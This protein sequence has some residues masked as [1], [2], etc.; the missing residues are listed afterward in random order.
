MVSDQEPGEKVDLTTLQHAKVVHF[1]MNGEKYFSICSM[2]RNTGSG[3]IDPAKTMNLTTD[4]F[5]ELTKVLP[6][7]EEALKYDEEAA[8]DTH[9]GEDPCIHAFALYFVDESGFG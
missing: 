5:G 7:V 8:C 9:Q 6:Q 4:E 1:E 2:K 3:D